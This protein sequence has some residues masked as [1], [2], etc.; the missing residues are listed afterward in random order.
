MNY[1]INGINKINKKTIDDKIF[2][3]EKVDYV[4]CERENLIDNLINWISE[5]TTDKEIMKN[6]LKYLMSIDN[7]Y[8]LSSIT[9][10]EYLTE[11][12]GQDILSEI[13]KMK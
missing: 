5:A 1:K 3:E 13:Y 12:E 4:I 10:N 11:E 8:I 2:Q 9:T 6:D 7:E